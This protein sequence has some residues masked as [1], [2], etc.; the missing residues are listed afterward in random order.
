MKMSKP[1]IFPQDFKFIRKKTNLNSD[2]REK[3]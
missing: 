1:E 2:L 3:S